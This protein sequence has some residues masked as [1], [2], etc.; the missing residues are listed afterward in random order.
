MTFRNEGTFTLTSSVEDLPDILKLNNFQSLEK[1][2]NCYMELKFCNSDVY[3]LNRRKKICRWPVITSV[4]YINVQQL[5]NIG[6]DFKLP[7]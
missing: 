6:N 1:A 5:L 7:S 4:Q 3:F 2:M